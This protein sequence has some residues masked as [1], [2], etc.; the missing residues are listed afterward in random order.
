MNNRYILSV[1][2][3]FAP[4]SY[5]VR[6][7]VVRIWPERSKVSFLFLSKK[8]LAMKIY[9]IYWYIYIWW[10]MVSFQIAE[11]RPIY[12]IKGT[13]LSTKP[14][15]SRV[16]IYCFD[17]A[18]H[19]WNWKLKFKYYVLCKSNRAPLTRVLAYKI[20]KVIFF[21]YLWSR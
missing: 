19:T 20:K 13:L 16:E 8:I 21:L 7:T 9:D 18:G 2:Y 6:L 17:S 12:F 4:G 11:L 3:F 10:K 1:V 14:S 5:I 15:K